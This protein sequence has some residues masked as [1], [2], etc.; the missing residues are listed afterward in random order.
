MSVLKNLKEASSL[1]DLATI[2]GYK[3]SALAYIIY[4]IPDEKKYTKFTIP[5]TGGGE[6][7]ICAPIEP[8][9]TLQRR[10]AN[11]LY[12]CRDEIDEKSGRR[13]LS[14]VSG[15]SCRSS[16]TRGGISDADT[17]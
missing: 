8:L 11:V 17:F 12:A 4:K 14:P 13:P 3:P 15:V 2:L 9:K 5:K 10:L 6:R 16:P 1:T 7:E